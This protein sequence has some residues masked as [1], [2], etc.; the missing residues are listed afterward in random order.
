MVGGWNSFRLSAR[1][2][3]RLWSQIFSYDYLEEP[4]AK[5]GLVMP[6]ACP[7]VVHG[8][9]LQKAGTNDE[10]PPACPVESHVALR[11]HSFLAE[12]SNQA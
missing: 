1:D 10:M 7:V 8:G 6:R 3:S 5:L 4:L 9:P 12:K 11:K 2:N